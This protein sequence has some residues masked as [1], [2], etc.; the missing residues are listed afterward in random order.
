MAARN[1]ARLQP[2]FVGFI[3]AVLLAL[4]KAPGI[5]G[6]TRAGNGQ[7][8]P[9]PFGP[10]IKEIPVKVYDNN[11]KSQQHIACGTIVTNVTNILVRN[12]H[13]P[14]PTFTK[15]ICEIVIEKADRSVNKLDIKFKHLELYRPN[16]DGLCQHDKFAVYT[17]LNAPMSPILC[18][19]Q[20]GKMI[21]VPFL[22]NQACLIV[23][24]ITSDLD[25]DRSWTI[26]IEQSVG[27]K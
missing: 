10:P 6:Q 12:P 17:D 11:I 13:H 14:E 18:G 2:H 20:T 9:H 23:S 27:N 3:L 26:E 1:A 24:I 5:D 7:L 15:V 21:S 25:H 22:P 16:M 8:V 4:S 19:S